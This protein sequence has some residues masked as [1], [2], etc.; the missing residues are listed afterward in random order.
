LEKPDAGE[1]GSNLRIYLIV[2]LVAAAVYAA[3][4]I[5]PPSLMDDVDAVQAQISRNML[6]SGDWVTARLDGVAYFEKSPLIYWMIAG[7]FRLFGA[8]DV[9]ARIPMVLAAPCG[10]DV[11]RMLGNDAWFD[12]LA[13]VYRSAQHEV[14]SVETFDARVAA[15]PRPLADAHDLSALWRELPC[16]SGQ[17]QLAV[18]VQSKKDWQGMLQVDG[19]GSANGGGSISGRK[20]CRH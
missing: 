11:A 13:R 4:M 7:C 1:R 14:L 6:T 10:G 2:L 16:D 12:A 8:T 5:S 3:C 20:R 18:P 17:W 19:K 9:V 15:L